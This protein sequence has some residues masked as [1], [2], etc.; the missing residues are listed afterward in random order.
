MTQEPWSH[1][2]PLP[3]RPAARRGPTI[4]NTPLPPRPAPAAPTAHRT[5]IIGV[6]HDRTGYFTMRE[7]LDTLISQGHPE[8]SWRNVMGDRDWSLNDEETYWNTFLTRLSADLPL[9]TQ[10]DRILHDD[11]HQPYTDMSPMTAEESLEYMRTGRIPDS[12]TSTRIPDRYAQTMQAGELPA[13]DPATPA[14]AEG[15]RPDAAPSLH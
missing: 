11:Y 1:G 15:M 6:N 9:R 12:Y 5:R 2:L 14:T 4:E 8:L 13:P 3:P 10:Y 7:A